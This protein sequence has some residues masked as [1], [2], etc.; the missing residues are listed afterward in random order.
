MAEDGGSEK[1]MGSQAQ[2]PEAERATAPGGAVFVSYASQDSAVAESICTALE[3]DGI[4]CW[5][6]PRDVRPG[7]FYADAIV[8]A[9]NACQVLVLV[10]SENSIASAHVLREVERASAK[11][12]P[13]ISLRIDAT[14]LPT[15]LE[16][17]LSTSQWLDASGGNLA[18]SFP[19]LVEAVRRRAATP[20]TPALRGPTLE[21]ARPTATHW[22]NRALIAAVI[23][24]GA[25][26][27]YILADKFWLSHQGGAPTTASQAAPA[28][29]VPAAISERSV[30][31]LPFTDLSAGK[32]QEYFS[33]GLSEELIDLLGKI[34]GLHVP[35]RTSSFYFKGKQATLGEIAKALRVSHV[36]EGSVRK[37]GNDVRITADLVRV[38]DEAQLWS[39]TYDRKLDDIFKLQDEIASAVV[40]AL[41]VSL[42]A[43]DTPKVTHAANIEAYTLYLQ[44]RSSVE[45]VNLADNLK[46]QEY[47]QRSLKLDPTY[48]PAWAQ[49]SR[50]RLVAFAS[51]GEGT[52][53]ASRQGILDAA[54][55]AIKLDPQLAAAHAALGQALFADDWDWNGAD[56]E[57]KKALELD[58]ADIDSLYVAAQIAVS[59]GRYQEARRFSQSAV[60]G[61][62][63]RAGG[64]RQLATAYYLGGQLDDAEA[65]VRKALELSPTGDS[66]HYKLALV[67]LMRNDAQG[68]LAEMEREPHAGWRQ[69]GLPLALDALGRKADADRALAIAVKDGSQGWAYQTALIYARRNDADS[70]FAWL[71]RAY[72]MRD[73]G[74]ANFVKG[75]PMLEALRAD[76]RYPALL[77]KMKLPV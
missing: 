14:P 12:R 33:D 42:L 70:A 52:L 26:I 57:V 37:A 8:Q 15:G 45:R 35:A 11:Q 23:L 2:A 72:E 25:G 77:R 17:F 40:K 65:A 6:A 38:D 69:Q 18:R 75:D 44:G 61:D 58:P 60:A 76:P 49:L 3:K 41:K 27:L 30:A 16:Y 62:P 28:A 43:G 56:R 63:L 55:Q 20:A 31:V 22:G 59:Q 13:V 68:A 1:S 64:Y 71:N 19:K 51:F 48:A 53:E 66:L 10:L 21:S 67:L 54:N 5:I 7:D 32:D 46:G 74:L 36:L 34:P 39:E 50:A 47:L 24:I 9:I 29:A 73:P 4:A